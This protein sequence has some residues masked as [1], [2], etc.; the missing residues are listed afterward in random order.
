MMT[1]RALPS[2][3]DALV[4]VW[5]AIRRRGAAIDRQLADSHTLEVGDRVVQRDLLSRRARRA[6]TL[7]RPTR[8]GLKRAWLV[9]LDEPGRFNRSGTMRITSDQL[10]RLESDE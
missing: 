7:V 8:I 2:V 1:V 3:R 9:R 6:G 10:A 5:S 4:G